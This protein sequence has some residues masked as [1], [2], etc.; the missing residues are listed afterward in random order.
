MLNKKTGM[1][2]IIVFILTREV[3]VLKTNLESKT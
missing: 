3:Q 1:L 2:S